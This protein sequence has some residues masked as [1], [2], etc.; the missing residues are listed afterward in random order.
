MISV[1]TDKIIRLILI[2]LQHKATA[3]L[4]KLALLHLFSSN[5]NNVTVIG[6]C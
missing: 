2:T 1:H 3:I 6:S 5:E 4:W